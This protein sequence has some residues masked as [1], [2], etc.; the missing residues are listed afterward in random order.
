[1]TYRAILGILF[2]SHQFLPGYKCGV[3]A[4]VMGV[5][6]GLS[7]DTSLYIA[8]IVSLYKIQQF[9]YVS[10]QP[11]APPLSLCNSCC[12][13]GYRKKKIERKKF[14]C[15][16]CAPCPDGMFTNQTDKETCA[17]C[18]EG[19]YA[20]KFHN[21]CILKSPN[22]LAFG[23]TLGIVSIFFGFVLSLITVFVLVIFI[24]HQDTAVVKANNIGLTY[25][26]LVS[27]LL[28]FLSSLLFIGVPSKACCLFRQTTFGTVFSIAL[29]S[30]L[31]KTVSVI[32]AFTATKPGSQMRRWLGKRLA[33]SILLSCSSFQAGLC[34][35]WLFTS[36]PFPDLDM[37]S[38]PAEFILLCNEGSVAM[39]YCVLG[40]MGFLAIVSFTVAFLARKLPG[41]FNEAKFITFSM[42][43][44]CSVWLSFLPAYFSTRGRYTVA[45]EI[46][47]ILASGAALLSCIFFPKCYIILLRP[48]LNKRE[49][50]M[51]KR[52]N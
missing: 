18:P 33:Y 9:A 36:P 6:G 41:C 51:Q 4:N 40:Y 25:I 34:A 15:Y 50:L 17:K 29:S 42:L 44:F 38:L 8:D 28:C 31:A 32:L 27:L 20:N 35:L 24:M 30:I 11:L 37:H 43:V 10:S 16:D 46:F 13:P 2:K 48:D 23:D 12:R 3:Q 22:F 19:H 21:Q 47:S 49:Q 7:S 52:D 45:V 14:C 5:V 39:F 1:M 26:L